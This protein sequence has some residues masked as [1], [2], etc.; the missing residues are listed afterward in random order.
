MEA[1]KTLV[2]I[3]AALTFGVAGPA[4]ALADDGESN[5][6][7]PVAATGTPGTAP[8]DEADDQGQGED[9]TNESTA[10]EQQSGENGDVENTDLAQEVEQV[11][12]AANDDT[13]NDETEVAGD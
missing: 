12:G 6:K 4:I 3:A 13:V 1:K 7:V 5:A 2:L 11:D 9:A 10:D 8:A